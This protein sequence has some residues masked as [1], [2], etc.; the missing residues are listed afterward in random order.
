MH[1]HGRFGNR[2]FALAVIA[3]PPM[4]KTVNAL[5]DR[6]AISFAQDTAVIAITAP[7]FGRVGSDPVHLL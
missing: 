6:I 1:R 3:L 7:G 2:G 5:E 4:F